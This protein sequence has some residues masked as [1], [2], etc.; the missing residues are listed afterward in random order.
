MEDQ[1]YNVNFMTTDAA[2]SNWKQKQEETKKC[3]LEMG[4]KIDNP[5]DY[6]GILYAD[7][8]SKV[9]YRRLTQEKLDKNEEYQLKYH[10]RYFYRFHA[11]LI[12]PL[13]SLF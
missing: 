12:H 3:Y 10:Y 6:N 9:Y 4:G 8:F 7:A 13:I 1:R 11:T 5:D 2:D